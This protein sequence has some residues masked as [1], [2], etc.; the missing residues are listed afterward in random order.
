MKVLIGLLA[1]FTLNAC[2]VTGQNTEQ[3]KKSNNNMMVEKFDQETYEKTQ[4]GL[5][6]YV[7][8]D[9]AII[10]SMEFTK[11]HGGSQ[12]ERLPS[13][14]FYTR[15]K[16]FY[17]NGNL[18]KKEMFLGEHVKVG[19]SEY[20]REDGSMERKTDENKKF[21]KV[22]PED[23]LQYLQGKGYINLKTG[24]GREGEDG[25]P[26]F[27]LDFTEAEGKKIWIV[28][29]IK[30]KPNAHPDF[31]EGEPP[32][33]LPVIFKVDGETGKEIQ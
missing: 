21:G 23:I 31:E 25:R 29:I 2:N 10:Y 18:K 15:Y 19:T 20:Y 13:P 24:Q 16:E 6:P 1:L 26:V 7:K 11:G 28:T 22:K 9:G 27:T 17:A 3:N 14:S 32:A 12:E 33:Y 30:G 8:S 4:N 5:H